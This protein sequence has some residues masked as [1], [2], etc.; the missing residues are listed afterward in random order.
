MNS[1]GSGNPT[2]SP[3]IRMNT[4]VPRYWKNPEPPART[5]AD[6]PPGRFRAVCAATE[7]AS[8]R[9]VEARCRARWA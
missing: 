1:A 8:E 6:L 7:V 9:A 4:G 2:A 5:G 3:D